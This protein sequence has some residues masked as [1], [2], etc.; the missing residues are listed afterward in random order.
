MFRI[1]GS[2]GSLTSAFHARR[3]ALPRWLLAAPFAAS[4][5][6]AVPARALTISATF[7]SSITSLS[8]AAQ[9]EAG[10]NAA[11]AQFQADF[12]D[13]ITINITFKS[14]PGTSIFG[15]SGASGQFIGNYATLK[16]VLLNDSKSAD[17]ATMISHLPATD[18]TGG[19]SYLALYA[20]AKAL[21]LRSATNSASDGTVTI[22][23]G[24]SYTFDPNNRAV[25]GEYDFIGIAEHE[26]SEVMG[27]YGTANL[28]GSFG[29][30]DLVG[31][32]FGAGG[33][34]TGTLNLAAN[35]NNNYFCI[36]G[37]VTPLKLYNNHSNGEDD[38]DWGSGSN[39]AFNAFSSSGVKNDI[40]AVDIREMDV[41]GYDVPVP[42]P[43]SIGLLGIGC[44]GFLTR[45]RRVSA[46][47]PPRQ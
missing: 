4:L 21:G 40:S 8:N 27:R 17:D 1:L 23:A 9:W 43:T 22:G 42:E 28:G 11:D 7:D 13:P 35:Q 26:I 10:I 41:I 29:V 5:I 20:Q 47:M 24:F 14:N 38:K 2:V 25:A 3:R 34:G 31:Y 19:S 44:L 39:D 15:Q 6:I 37:G 16:T 32:Q 18:P 30:L 36:D 46:T 33:T 45:R 12:T